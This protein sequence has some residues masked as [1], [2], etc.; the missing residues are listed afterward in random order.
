MKLYDDTKPSKYIIYLGANNL[1]DWSVSQYLLYSTFKWLNKK[2]IDKFDVN[3]IGENSFDGHIL[4][5]DL[6]YPDKLHGLH[7]D[8][9]V[10]PENLKLVIICCQNIRSSVAN[11]Y[12]IKLVGVNKLVPTLGNKSNYV[13][14]YK[15]LELYL[16]LGMKL[17]SIHR[18][19]KFKQSDWLKKYI[20][21][22]TNKRKDAVNNFEKDLF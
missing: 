7:N 6:E 9:P 10:A 12:E 18:I 15:N 19:L 2:E 8:Y 22:N 13:L 11:Q 20:D 5:V 4:E 1:Y 14:H 17:F 16:S 21:F 3:L